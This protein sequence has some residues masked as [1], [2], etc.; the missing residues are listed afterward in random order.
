MSGRN[1]PS[2]QRTAN[3]KL[4]SCRTDGLE[5][6][7]GDGVVLEEVLVAASRDGRVRR[8]ADRVIRDV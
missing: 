8:V 3:E 1:V 2:G 7:V 4:R 6:N 5:A